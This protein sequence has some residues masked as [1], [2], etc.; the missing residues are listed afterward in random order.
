MLL[1]IQI[2]VW[3]NIEQLKVKCCNSDTAISFYYQNEKLE[4]IACTLVDDLMYGGRLN[5]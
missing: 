2:L 4:G 3:K 1:K 5:R